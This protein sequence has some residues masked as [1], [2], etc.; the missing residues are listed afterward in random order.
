VAEGLLESLRARE[1]VRG[2][3]MLYAAAEGARDVLPTGLAALGAQ[4]DIIALYRNGAA[5]E[6]AAPVRARLELGEV[7]LVTFASASAVH[8]F[9]SAVGL[10]AARRVPAASI[11]PITTEAAREAGLEVVREATASTI[12]GLVDAVVRALAGSPLQSAAS[13][14][15]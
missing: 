14:G 4:V 10:E 2:A 8:A 1:D 15:A 13:L 12:S 6:D 9:V 7:D 11:G 3:H 5:M